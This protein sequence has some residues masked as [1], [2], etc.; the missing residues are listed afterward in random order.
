MEEPEIIRIDQDPTKE[1][2]QL[3]TLYKDDHRG[4]TRMWEIMFDGKNKLVITYGTVEGEK[5]TVMTEVKLNTTGRDMKQQAILEARSRY[6]E[7][8]R[9]DG[10]RPSGD[11]TPMNKEPMLAYKW[12]SHE[13]ME[14]ALSLLFRLKKTAG[15]GKRKLSEKKMGELRK[16][17]P[18]TEQDL[19]NAELH[20]TKT[21][22]WKID[23]KWSTVDYFP[24]AVQ[25]KIDGIRL[26]CSLTGTKVR[27]L[28][29]ENSE[30][31]HLRHIIDDLQLFFSYFP[32]GTILDGE[33]Y[34]EGEQ[35]NSI[36]SITRR[37]T[38]PYHPRLSELK[39]YIF[40]IIT[41]TPM[42]FTERYNLLVSAY[43]KYTEEFQE[44]AS[45]NFMIVSVT[46]A[47]SDEEIESFHDQYTKMGY[48]GLMIRYL[49]SDDPEMNKK[50]MYVSGYTPNLLKYKKFIDEEAVIIGVDQ[51]SGTEEGAAMLIVRDI[52][53]N[54]L[55]IRMRAPIEERRQWF[56]NPQS[57]IGKL[58][59][60][61]YQELSVYKVPRFPVGVAIRDY[62]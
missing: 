35:F 46:L 23:Q 14:D 43:Q 10:Y 34:I 48:E 45:K 47:K 32:R 1:K 22:E 25:A 24:V 9:T 11:E 6:N 42:T 61:R 53:A 7:K 13:K 4:V 28:T 26:L 57:I 52:R 21:G 59:T 55:K 41:P 29:R 54:Q 39:Y 19:I 36:A 3:E 60:I 5:T 38:Q 12:V 50:S 62:E 30:Y 27:C 18:P 56:Q 8:F 58:A 37:Q 49:G 16:L 2:W 20:R 17:P 51:G 31:Q 44:R 33:L 40:D 15:R